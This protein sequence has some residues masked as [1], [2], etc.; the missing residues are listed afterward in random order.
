MLDPKEGKIRTCILAKRHLSIFLLR[1]YSYGDNTAVSWCYK[2]ALLGYYQHTIRRAKRTAWQ[3]FCSDIEKT[4]DAATLRK[5]LSKTAAPLGY[6]QRENGSW[7]DS[8][9]APRRSLPREATNRSSSRKKSRRGNRIR[10]P[11]IRPQH[12][13]V[14][15]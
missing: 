14:Y 3:T 4:T 11:P 6:L 13:M 9:P 12:E 2:V 5:I 1:N 15:S 8:R 10:S 7:S